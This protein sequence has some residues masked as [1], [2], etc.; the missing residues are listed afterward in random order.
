MSRFVS[1]A[2]AALLLAGTSLAGA[3]TYTPGGT[4]LNSPSNADATRS[5]AN[6]TNTPPQTPS[7]GALPQQGGGSAEGQWNNSSTNSSAGATGASASGTGTTTSGAAGTGTGDATAG[8][9]GSSAQ[10]TST[11]AAQSHHH[12]RQQAKTNTTRHQPGAQQ[13]SSRSDGT[14]AANALNSL[15]AAG[16]Y[17]IS[18]FNVTNNGYTATATRNGQE[19]RV[20]IDRSGQI[21]P[22]S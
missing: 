19:S 20:M 5:Q 13:S 15:I 21:Q 7:T 8:T 14:G 4:G 18:D 17:D 11:Q 16:Y 3:Q 2:A 6:P 9:G 12:R 10:G 1:A 22:A